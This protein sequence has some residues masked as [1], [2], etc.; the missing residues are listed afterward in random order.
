MVPRIKSAGKFRVRKR[1]M[2]EKNQRAKEM[3]CKNTPHSMKQTRQ[4]NANGQIK[5]ERPVI[6]DVEQHPR[7]LCNLVGIR[8]WF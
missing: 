7:C 2:K 8:L 5:D 4:N 6:I 3:K 1:C